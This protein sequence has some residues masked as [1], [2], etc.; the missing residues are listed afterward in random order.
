MTLDRHDIQRRV[1]HTGAMCLLVRVDQWDV[2][3]I[4][5]TAL[6]VN[7]DHPLSRY[8]RL[9]AVAAAEYAAQASAVHG[10]LL[11]DC[12]RAR[13][14]L[15]ARLAD[16]QWTRPAIVAEDGLLR[17]RASVLARSDSGCAYAFTLDGQRGPL[18]TGR[19]T[20][21]FSVADDDVAYASRA[22]A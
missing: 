9:P 1:P 6:A 18:V 12:Q 5:C 2:Q 10:S 8:G 15:L 17:V 14:G 3:G 16:V 22:G 11:D 21:A 13:P 19:L 4:E 7:A 20:V